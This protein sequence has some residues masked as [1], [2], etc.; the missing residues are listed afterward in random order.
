[1]TA[2]ADLPAALAILRAKRDEVRTSFGVDLIGVVGSVARGEARSDSDLDV[3]STWLP[4][5]TLL[6]VGGAM[7]LLE[8]EV[9]REVQL[10]NSTMLKADMQRRMEADLVRL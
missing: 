3:L 4:G 6:K 10:V 8:D 9:G 5:T 1:M 2:P 7:V